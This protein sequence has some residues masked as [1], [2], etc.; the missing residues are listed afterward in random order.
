MV[1]TSLSE[2]RRGKFYRPQTAVT[3][4]KEG[5]VMDCR[6]QRKIVALATLVYVV[7]GYA[8]SA[9]PELVSAAAHTGA[10][11]P[12]RVLHF[13]QDGSVGTVRVQDEGLFI[14]ETVKGFHPGYVYAESEYLASAQGEVGIPAG[15]RVFL[16][17]EGVDATRQHCQAALKALDPNALYSL[18]FPLPTFIDDDLMR[19]VVRLRELREL[20]LPHASLTPKGWTMLA[21]LPRLERLYTP[22]GMSDAAMAQIANVQSLKVL[23]VAPNKMTNAGL[24]SLAR[25]SRLEILHLEGAPTM[26]DD[27]LKALTALGSLHHLRLSSGPFTDRGME[28]LA[29]IPSLR[30]LWVDPGKITDAGLQRLARSKSIERLNLHWVDTI[31]DRGVAYVKGMP[32]LKGLDVGHA[33]LSD[34]SLELLATMPNLD[35]LSLPN[36]GLSLQSWLHGR[37][38][39]ISLT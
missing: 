8:Y 9:G 36:T 18:M 24:A 31:T 34:A 25:L 26:T 21:Q 1:G 5:H 6:M 39:L 10:R 16:S 19:S 7:G 2:A 28:H 11:A 4:S 29:A 3:A 27:G 30:V 33:T 32:Q 12:A 22:E 38:N 13:P 20:R 35:W 23:N 15:K 37:L 14:P 17:V